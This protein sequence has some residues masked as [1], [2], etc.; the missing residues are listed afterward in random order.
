MLTEH[1][2]AGGRLL[3]QQSVESRTAFAAAFAEVL[4]RSWPSTATQA[5]YLEAYLARGGGAATVDSLETLLYR[6]HQLRAR[7]GTPFDPE[8]IAA[9][10]RRLRAR[11]RQPSWRR[12]R[13]GCTGRRPRR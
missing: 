3:V 7:W 2:F 1:A 6:A 5:P 9:A 4:R 11:S 8:R 12:A 13:P 10:A